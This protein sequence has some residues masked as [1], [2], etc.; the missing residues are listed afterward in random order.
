M[1]AGGF[2]ASWCRNALDGFYRDRS[3]IGSIFLQIGQD[4]TEFHRR[5]SCRHFP[6]SRHRWPDPPLANGIE[7]K[8]IRN[9]W[10][11]ARRGRTEFGD[12][13]IPV[14]DQHRFAAG[15]QPNVFAKLVFEMFDS[16]RSHAYHA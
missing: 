8:R 5:F 13:A 16:N 4:F 2:A 14:G 7:Q 9:Q 10:A 12:H 6:S 15:R 11:P 1:A 3:S